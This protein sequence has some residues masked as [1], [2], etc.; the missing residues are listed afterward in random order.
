MG[1]EL[2]EMTEQLNAENNHEAQ[3]RQ[4]W[5]S[6]VDEITAET[7]E[8]QMLRAAEGIRAVREAQRAQVNIYSFTRQMQQE[9]AKTGLRRVWQLR[10][11]GKFNLADEALQVMQ[12]YLC[13]LHATQRHAENSDLPQEEICARMERWV[14]E[15][16]FSMPEEKP[17][18]WPAL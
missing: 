2:R 18:L 11:A 13:A 12:E 5:D 7:V 6:V 9:I 14:M 17:V 16:E 8:Q 15:H 1:K 3:V 4:I 10:C